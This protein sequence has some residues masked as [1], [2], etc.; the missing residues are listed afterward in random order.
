M[1][2]V[3]TG[4][5][6]KDVAQKAILISFL[7]DMAKPLKPTASTRKEIATPLLWENPTTNNSVASIPN[8]TAVQSICQPEIYVQKSKSICPDFSQNTHTLTST[9]HNLPHISGG[10]D[11]IAA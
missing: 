2:K 10:D 6:E 5:I 3:R 1:N 11:V 7:P 8:P 4:H 9:V